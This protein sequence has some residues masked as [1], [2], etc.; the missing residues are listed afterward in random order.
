MK[1]TA[2]SRAQDR[3]YI[4]EHGCI[5]REGFCD[6][7]KRSRSGAEVES[8]RRVNKPRDVDYGGRRLCIEGGRQRCGPVPGRAGV[9]YRSANFQS[10]D[11]LARKDTQ[12]EML[13][14]H[15]AIRLL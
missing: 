12:R 14:W 2:E 1:T 8:R 7:S 3:K 4:K 10:I 15:G 6:S 11:S 13:W 5:E 9:A